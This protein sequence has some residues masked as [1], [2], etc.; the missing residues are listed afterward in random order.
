MSEENVEVKNKKKLIKIILPVFL[1]AILSGG[2]IWWLSWETP[3]VLIHE[4]HEDTY[5][6]ETDMRWFTMMNDGG[7]HT[8]E[9]YLVNCDSNFVHKFVEGYKANLGGTPETSS[10]M[11]YEKEIDEESMMKVKNLL[12]EIMEKEDI[13]E[14]NNYHPFTITHDDNNNM[15]HEEKTIYNEDTI[16][17]IK[18]LLKTIDEM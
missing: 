12:K 2:C 11:I 1:V 9:Y 4:L 3:D 7:S 17:E 16:K 8:N 15:I 10:R 13:N 18:V 5:K 6:I 14:S